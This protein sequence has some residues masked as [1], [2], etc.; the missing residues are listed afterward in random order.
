MKFQSFS[1]V[2]SG[3][4]HVIEKIQASAKNIGTKIGLVTDSNELVDA[5]G[6][7]V[8]DPFP[9]DDNI[10]YTG[11]K[12]PHM[13]YIV[14]DEDYFG[15]EQFC[16]FIF[17]AVRPLTIPS[18]SVL[19]EVPADEE[20]KGQKIWKSKK[21]SC[22]EQGKAINIDAFTFILTPKSDATDAYDVHVN[23]ILYKENHGEESYWFTAN[24]QPGRPNFFAVNIPVQKTVA[25][26]IE[27][28]SGS[29]AAI[30]DMSFHGKTVELI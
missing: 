24:V 26:K 28:W 27:V 9:L 16:D 2:N 18:A 5:T 7:T 30:S 15:K 1:M 6:A 8:T 17:E 13:A 10:V 20:I 29:Y 25:T 23:M 11:T 12:V 22:I 3:N 21:K 19:S 4:V 14:L